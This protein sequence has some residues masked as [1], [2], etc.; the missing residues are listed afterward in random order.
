MV[1]LRPEKKTNNH[2]PSVSRQLPRDSSLQ[3]LRSFLQCACRG[4]LTC[5]KIGDSWEIDDVYIV[6]C[7]GWW[8]TYPFEKYESQLGL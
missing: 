8:Y 7:T 2:R 3:T 4:K 5:V 1:N 6:T